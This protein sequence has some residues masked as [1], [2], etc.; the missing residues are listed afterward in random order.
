MGYCVAVIT[1][2]QCRR[3]SDLHAGL[4]AAHI[5]CLD[6]EAGLGRAVM[7]RGPAGRIVQD[8]VSWGWSGREGQERNFT[9]RLLYRSPNAVLCIFF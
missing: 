2:F 9:T 3:M 6:R 1:P 4:A 8:W 7:G 5:C